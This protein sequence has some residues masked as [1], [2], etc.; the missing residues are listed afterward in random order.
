[1]RVAVSPIP[2]YRN[3]LGRNQPPARWLG[4]VQR[5]NRLYMQN[6]PEN[7][8]PIDSTASHAVDIA[9]REVEGG[10]IHNVGM[11]TDG[12]YGADGGVSPDLSHLEDT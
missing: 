1:M 11:Q 7:H 9:I 8:I 12:S 4:V 2:S 3:C 10:A 5:G 6:R